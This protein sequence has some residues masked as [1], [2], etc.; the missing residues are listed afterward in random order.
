MKR[1]DIIR[2]VA[3]VSVLFHAFVASPE[4]RYFSVAPDRDSLTETPTLDKRWDEPRRDG[5][6]TLRVN[7]LRSVHCI[8]ASLGFAVHLK[9]LPGI[10][11]VKTYVNSHQAEIL[12]D[13]GE[14]DE[15]AIRE[16]IFF[17]QAIQFRTPP[18][19]MRWLKALTIRTDRTYDLGDALCLAKK[20][21]I[22]GMRC[23]GLETEYA[24]PMIVRVWTAPDEM[25]TPHELEALIEEKEFRFVYPNGEAETVETDYDFV[26]FELTADS[27]SRHKFV[28]AHFR[29]IDEVYAGKPDTLHT[30]V[31]D[32]P[33]PELGDCF[34]GDQ[35]SYLSNYLESRE[36]I[37]GLRTELDAND[38]PHIY[39]RYAS[40][41]L[42]ERRILT[43]IL[44]A[45]EWILTFPDGSM[46]KISACMNF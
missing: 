4:S 34:V 3:S 32:I 17:P 21:R 46:R 27:I 23:Y 18:S 16:G 30:A 26:R 9:T 41:F 35:L 1:I 19:E 14:T 42:D 33:Y 5:L 24:V 38:L 31:M 43:E 36:G 25:F 37:L 39:I 11:G 44:R 29:E 10:Y 8:G 6:A 45:P 7:G 20:F 28:S 2:T 40:D 15:S 13:P 22:S 12:Y